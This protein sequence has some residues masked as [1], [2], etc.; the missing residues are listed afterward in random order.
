MI[1]KYTKYDCCG[2]L[3]CVDVCPENIISAKIDEQGF[4]YPYIV[5]E[6]IDQCTQCGKCINKCAFNNKQNII[7]QQKA[8]VLAV[9]HR[10]TEE[11]KLSRSGAF[12]PELSR[13]VI[14]NSGVVYGA[15]FNSSFSVEHRRE[16]E[17]KECDKF[18]G[19]K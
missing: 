4:Y 13:W 6:K 12:A 1:S 10:N 16:T 8:K 15:V 5:N 2:C 17:H 18:R 7:T 14:N 3:A 9:R 11:V 19:S